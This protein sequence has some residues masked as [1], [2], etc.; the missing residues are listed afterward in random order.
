ML[1]TL[2]VICMTLG[3][4]FGALLTG[5]RNTTNTGTIPNPYVYIFGTIGF[6]L[7][8]VILTETAWKYRNWELILMGSLLFIVGGAG[9]L[10]TVD[11]FHPFEFIVSSG[12]KKID[13]A[14][15]SAS[16]FLI[17]CLILETRFYVW[18]RQVLK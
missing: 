4:V 5:T 13:D 2:G 10:V 6:A 8:G 18:K 3:G 9:T 1:L 17:I 12:N 14:L 15:Y 16:I 11:I 7:A